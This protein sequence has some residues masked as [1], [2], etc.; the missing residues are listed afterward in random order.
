MNGKEIDKS[1]TNEYL[2]VCSVCTTFWNPM[3][4]SQLLLPSK[5]S[6]AGMLERAVISSSK[7]SSG[8][9]IKPISPASPALAGGLFTTEPPGKPKWVLYLGSKSISEDN[10]SKGKRERGRRADRGAREESAFTVSL[11]DA[12]PVL[13]TFYGP[14]NPNVRTSV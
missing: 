14:W 12:F 10:Q 1:F 5:I 2:P 3:Y 6:Q 8:Q 11:L 13:T 4:C 7:E 9:W